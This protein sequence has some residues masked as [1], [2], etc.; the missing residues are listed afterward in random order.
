MAYTPQGRL[1]TGAPG[2]VFVGLESPPVALQGRRAPSSALARLEDFTRSL[3]G[4]SQAASVL[5]PL[6]LATNAMDGT[7]VLP[8]K[9]SQ[10]ANLYLFIEGRPQP[11]LQR[12]SQ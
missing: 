7:A 12:R 2:S 6:T 8:W 3:P 4:V 9:R 11:V 1:G 10:A 5:L